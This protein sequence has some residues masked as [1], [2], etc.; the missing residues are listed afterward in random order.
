MAT[1][2][3]ESAT[4]DT[5]AAP[6]RILTVGVPISSLDAKAKVTTSLSMA[7]VLFKLLEAMVIEPD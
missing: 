7:S 6:P 1:Q 5:V 3:L 2:L 4:F